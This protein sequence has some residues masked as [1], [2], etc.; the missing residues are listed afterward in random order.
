MEFFWGWW[1]FG[2]IISI[3]SI[4]GYKHMSQI[5]IYDITTLK[6]LMFLSIGCGVLTFLIFIG[7]VLLAL[8]NI[9]YEAIKESIKGDKDV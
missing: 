6:E 5:N 9:S 7:C 1:I 4:W 3:W 2:L 8:V